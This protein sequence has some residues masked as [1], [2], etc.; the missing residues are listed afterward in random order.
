[1]A[2]A[3]NMK[4]KCSEI[5]FFLCDQGFGEKKENRK[6]LKYVAKFVF[7]AYAIT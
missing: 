3:E 4:L 7:P 5:C 2:N 1:M 6:W